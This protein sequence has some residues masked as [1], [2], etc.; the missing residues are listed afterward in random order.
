MIFFGLKLDTYRNPSKNRYKGLNFHHWSVMK[1]GIGYSKNS[2]AFKAGQEIVQT[3]IDKAGTQQPDLILAFCTVRCGWRLKAAI[4]KRL[5]EDLKLS[6]TS[7][8]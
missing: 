4:L 1:I 8:G 5:K 3:A 6:Y 2:D 7:A